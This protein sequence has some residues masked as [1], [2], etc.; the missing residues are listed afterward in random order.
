MNVVAKS[1]ATGPVTLS[2][3]NEDVHLRHGDA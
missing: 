3:A 2:A 1:V